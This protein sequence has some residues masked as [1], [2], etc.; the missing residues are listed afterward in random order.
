M[1]KKSPQLPL[2]NVDKYVYEIKFL[3]GRFSYGMKLFIVKKVCYLERNVEWF[4][5]YFVFQI[6]KKI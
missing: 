4:R 3:C 5:K 2:F 6:N 1:L